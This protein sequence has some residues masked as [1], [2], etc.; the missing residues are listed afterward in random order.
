MTIESHDATTVQQ[1]PSA[2]IAANVA[3]AI[4]EDVG[5]GDITA[6]LIGV[7]H[8][9]TAVVITREHGV[10]CGRPWGQETCR[11]VDPTIAS[12]WL[13]GEGALIVPDQPLLKLKGPTR[14]LLTVERSLLNFLQLLSGTATATRHYLDLLDGTSCKLLDTRKTLP[15]LRAAQKYAVRTAGG[16]NPR[17]GLFDAFLIKENHLTAASSIIDAVKHARMLM[18]D[19]VVEVEVESLA[20]LSDAIAAAADIA[21]IDN[22]TL[23]MTEQAVALARDKILLEASGGIDENTITDIARAGVDYISV[24]NLTKEVSPLDLSMRIQD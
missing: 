20:Q 13:V 11:Q 6:Q 7:E 2:C 4:A 3:A 18:P 17:M 10:F 19:A 9:S 21:L 5:S 8:H 16:S 24:G 14:G 23:A 22:F 12:E 15:G 1:P